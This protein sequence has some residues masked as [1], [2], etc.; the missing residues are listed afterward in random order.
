M[1]GL[2]LHLSALFHAHHDFLIFTFGMTPTDLFTVSIAAQSFWSPYFPSFSVWHSVWGI[3]LSSESL[4]FIITARKQSFR[5]YVFTPVCQSFCSQGG[6]WSRGVV[7][8]QAPPGPGTLPGQVPPGP[9]TPPWA[10]TTPW[11]QVHPHPRDQVHTPLSSA[12]WGIG[13]TSGWYASYKNA[14]LLE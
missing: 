10:G 1:T 14:F 3:H 11:D 6:T 12:C 13:A 5:R 8:G 2:I 9:G 4:V 7:P